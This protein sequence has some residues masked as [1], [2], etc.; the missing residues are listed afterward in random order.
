M[1]LTRKVKILLYDY[2]SWLKTYSAQQAQRVAPMIA[3]RKVVNN[4]TKW[5][6]V[7]EELSGV[8]PAAE[9][10]PLSQ[11]TASVAP[12]EVCCSVNA[13]VDIRILRNFR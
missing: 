11:P 7:K 8:T 1:R 5:N 6:Q 4:I 3:S 10:P 2:R 9:N 13:Y 12:K